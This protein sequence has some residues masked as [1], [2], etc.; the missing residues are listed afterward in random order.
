M[1]HNNPIKYLITPSEFELNVFSKKLEKVLDEHE[2]ACVRLEQSTRDEMIIGKSAD[3]LR[4]IC[5]KRDIPLIIESHF[6]LVEKFG[7]DGVHLNDGSKSI[8][9]ARKILGKESIVGAYCFQSKHDGINATE[10]GADY[11]SFGPM[12]GDLGD[13]KHA[14]PKLFEWWGEMIE[15]PV[16]AETGLT[17][18]LVEQLQIFCDFLAFREEIWDADN[19]SKAL[20]HFFNEN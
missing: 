14:D 12:S 10:A 7:L 15:F 16:I 8:R 6:M 4:E 2:V 13:G 17:P 19:P 3:T 9:A 1:Q 11:V 18:Q 20:A 5:H